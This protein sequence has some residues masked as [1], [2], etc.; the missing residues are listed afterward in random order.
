MD[1][2]LEDG[3]IVRIQLSLDADEGPG[4]NGSGRLGEQDGG[5]NLIL[6]A[7]SCLWTN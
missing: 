6:N 3:H 1:A 2:G 4:P 5:S 7:S